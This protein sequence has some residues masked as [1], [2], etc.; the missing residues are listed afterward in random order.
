MSLG[1]PPVAFIGLVT[2]Q[3]GV[4]LQIA[5]GNTSTLPADLASTVRGNFFNCA[6]YNTISAFATLANLPAGNTLTIK[7]ISIDPE[8]GVAVVGSLG[9][10]TLFTLTA[11]GNYAGTSYLPTIYASLSSAVLPLYL[12]QVTLAHTGATAGTLDV[13]AFKLWLS[14]A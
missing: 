8:T 14:N 7:L 11:N 10:L 4:P 5:K 2:L 9:N 3:T 1:L 13:S 12:E 6:G